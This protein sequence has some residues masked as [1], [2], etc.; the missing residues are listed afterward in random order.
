MGKVKGRRYSHRY[1][2]IEKDKL[3]DKEEASLHEDEPN[4]SSLSP[5]HLVKALHG[6][7][8]ADKERACRELALAELDRETFRV[9][10]TA[11]N[12]RVICDITASNDLIRKE[13]GV[14]AIK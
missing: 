4:S 8:P 3:R 2:P 11:D 1:N 14:S 5:D 6:D 10:T 13:A 9:L 7:N 12:L